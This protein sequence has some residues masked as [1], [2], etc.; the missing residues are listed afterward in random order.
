VCAGADVYSQV[1]PP[2]EGTILFVGIE[3]YV[4]SISV[5]RIIMGIGEE[6]RIYFRWTK[7][8]E[9]GIIVKGSNFFNLRITQQKS[10][11]SKPANFVVVTISSK[12]LPIN[13]NRETCS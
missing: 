3:K 11:N 4:T 1:N 12:L 7:I 6:L 5:V 8:S 2:Q 10:T 13:E 9:K